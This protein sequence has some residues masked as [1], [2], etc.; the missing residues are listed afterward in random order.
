MLTTHGLLELKARMLLAAE[1]AHQL[2][3]QDKPLEL[4]EQTFDLVTDALLALRSDARAL[5]AE[6]DILRGMTTGSFDSLFAQEVEHGRSPDV[7]GVQQQDAAVG[8]EGERADTPSPSGPVRSG[9]AD[10][11]EGGGPQPKR[12]RRRRKKDTEQL[13]SRS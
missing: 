3:S 7:V 2:V 8:G 5:L 10:G 11:E 12:N 6:V 13:D 1:A 4:D 9:G